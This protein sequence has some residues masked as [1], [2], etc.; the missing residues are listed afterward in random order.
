MHTLVDVRLSDAA[1]PAC[2]Q[3][4]NQVHVTIAAGGDI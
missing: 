3:C 2:K 1:R 4:M